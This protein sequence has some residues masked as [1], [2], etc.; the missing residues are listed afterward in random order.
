MPRH[1]RSAIASPIAFVPR[2]LPLAIVALLAAPPSAAGQSVVCEVVH[3]DA[4]GLIAELR[5]PARPDRPAGLP[6]T[7]S[8]APFFARLFA[9][10]PAAHPQLR[11]TAVESVDYKDIDW[12]NAQPPAARVASEYLGILRGVETHALKFFPYH[13]DPE[14]RVLTVHTRLLVAIRFAKAA[15]AHISTDAAQPAWDALLNGDLAAAGARP[16]AA[17]KVAQNDWYNPESPWLKLHVNEDGLYRINR[18]WL[19]DFV[20]PTTIDPRSLRL[21]NL[22]AE[23]P[24]HV[25]GEADGTFDDS[26]Y[27]LFH[28]RYRRDDYQP[29]DFSSPYGRD[30]TYWLTWGA[31]PGLRFA[32][33]SGA[34]VAG[35]PLQRS[36][37]TT[38][39][40]EQDLDYQRFDHAPN[41]DRD[42]W[43]WREPVLATKPDVPASAIFPGDLLF[44]DLTQEYAARIRVMLHGFLDLGHHTVIKLNNR[45]LIDD[46][47]W[48]GKREGQVELLIDEPI[49]STTLREGRNRVLLQVF[50]DQDKFDGILFNWFAID[51]RRLYAAW[52]GQLEWNQPASSGH[53]IAIG[54]LRHRQVELLDVANGIRFTDVAVD[55]TDAGFTATFEDDAAMDARYIV[56]DSLAWRTPRGEIDLPSRWGRSAWRTEYLVIAHRDLLDAAHRLAEHRQTQGLQTL[57][58]TV[59]DLYDEFSYGRRDRNAVRNFLTHAYRNWEGRP[60]Y[61]LLLG[62]DTWDYRNIQGGGVPAVVP[63]LYYQSRGRGIA[64]SDYLYALVDGDDLLADFHIGRIAASSAEE[65]DAAVDKI[66]GYD[67]DPPPGEWRNRMIYLANHHPKDIFTEPSD[68]LAARYSEPAGLTSRRV[69]NT[70]ES[71]IP[72]ETGRTFVEAFN[73]GALLLNFNGHGS[74]GTMAFLFTLSLPDWDYLGQLRNGGRLPLVLAL[75]CLNGL[76]ASPTVEGLAEVLVN[77]PDRGAIAYISASAKSFVAQNDLLSHLFYEQLFARNNLRP[78][79]ALDA[80]KAQTL[81]AHSSWIDAALTMQLIGDPAQQLA[82]APGPD[83]EVVALDFAGQPRGHATLQLDATLR[84]NGRPTADSLAVLVLGHGAAATPDTLFTAVEPPFGGSRTLSFAWPIGARRGPYR[85]E[86]VLDGSGRLVELDEANNRLI[87]NLDILEPLSPIVLFP[88]PDAVLPAADVRLEVA[89]PLTKNPYR[90][91][92][93]LAADPDFADA[94]QTAIAPAVDGVAAYAFQ[95]LAAGQVY[96]W[97]ARLVSDRAPG[98]WTPLRS[99]RIGAPGPTWHQQGAQL[100]TSTIDALALDA[101]GLLAPAPRSLPF[102]PSEATR[103]DGFTVRNLQG[104]GVLVT[105]GTY[106]YAKRWYN[107]DSTIYPGIDFF[108]RIGTGLNDTFRSGNLGVLADSTTAGISATYHSDGYIYNESGKA[109]EIERIRAIDGVLDTVAVPM[110]LLEWK[111]G[112]VEN[113]HSLITSDGTHIYNVAMSS[114]RGT[115]TEWRIRVFDPAD[116]WSLVREFTSPPT[117]NGFTYEWTDGVLADGER[118]YL[119]EWEGQ[120]RIRMIDAYDGTFLDEWQSGQEVTRVIT[121]QYDWIN[122]KV[123]MGDLLSSAVFRYA[124]LGRVESGEIT[125]PPI[126]PATD[127]EEMSVEGSG[128]LAIDV[129]VADGQEWKPV[130]EGLAAGAVRLSQLEEGQDRQIRLRARLLDPSARLSSWSVAFT[131]SPS[132][133][134]AAAESDLGPTGLRIA[135]TI[136]NFG[137]AHAG[138]QL[139]LEQPGASAPL[140]TLILDPLARGETRIAFFDSLDLPPARTRIFAVLDAGSPDATPGDNRLEIPLF[141]PGHVPLDVAL[142]PGDASFMTGDPLR[143]G[144]GLVV[145]VPDLPD[146]RVELALDGAPIAPD[147]TLEAFPAP[148][149]LLWRPDSALAAGRHQLT[150]TVFR[151]DEEIGRRKISFRYNGDLHIANALP[152]PHPVRDAAAF[153]YVLSQSAEVEI[154]I[155]SLTG[156]LIRRLGPRAQEPGFR[157]ID[158]DGRDGAGK[159]LAN[160]TYLYRI[161]ARGAGRD[162]VFRGPLA[163]AR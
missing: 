54:G 104:S 116:E 14:S 69:Y 75:S 148:P 140:R 120:R 12:P 142:W 119:V 18:A 93:A 73:D 129:L 62:D 66:I 135:V 115:R 8:H 10:P 97:R 15:P 103:E 155:Y 85:L 90:C 151:G 43:F 161:I 72:N 102:R 32:E 126:G 28:G 141:L 11:V 27:L 130:W 34:P 145:A 20:D 138:A 92:F 81:A 127:W 137:P 80:A 74:A 44:P 1:A 131:P 35:H 42:H 101:D 59:D 33:R 39:H 107:D 106:L 159:G 49:A 23:R 146:A 38:A 117:D 64:P 125:S 89:V 36:F 86:I 37:W 16:A 149:R 153:T 45:H 121:G 99:F 53:R 47:I 48:G 160:G 158:W 154:E 79:P 52:F 26:D 68:A 82:L 51:Y 109:F 9:S 111:Y 144:Q 118:L 110:G 156:R 13:Y 56:A 108:T 96:F 113:G 19:A 76:F 123:W 84:N 2:L 25:A 163:V 100:F 114:E 77:E 157:Q 67:L 6:R 94:V 139:R 60:A 22:G 71:P 21:F 162:A 95:D 70:D 46:R 31:E 150:A 4:G 83:Y 112:R 50:A 3:S 55:S 91:E 40:F 7:D 133:A 63:S 29:R 57:V 87:R 147:S 105:D 41:I 122:N 136:R 128:R 30:N 152:Y 65:A 124:G 78:G 134:V 98:A 58:A 17:F 61:V 24:L 132:L 88:S 5:L 143:P